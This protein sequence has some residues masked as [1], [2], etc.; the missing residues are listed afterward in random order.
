ML[1]NAFAGQANPP[2]KKD[3][4]SVLG[5]ADLLWQ[6]LVTD[7]QRDLKLDAAEWNTYS[8][9]AGWSLRLKLKKRNIV[10]LGPRAGCFLASF[11]LGDKALAAAR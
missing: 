3:L 7:L 4:A 5:R 8:V 2:T 11:I 10:Y 9:K 1:P 6:D